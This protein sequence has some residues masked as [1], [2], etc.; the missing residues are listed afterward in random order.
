MYAIEQV[1]ALKILPSR[2]K[3][4]L[5][6]IIRDL[7]LL[8]KIRAS[9]RTE[10]FIA[11]PNARLRGCVITSA[12]TKEPVAILVVLRPDDTVETIV[13]VLVHE[14]MHY[15]I[16]KEVGYRASRAYD[17]VAY[18]VERLAELRE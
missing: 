13:K 7:L 4:L 11:A 10:L 1:L 16:N 17:R 15:T 2:I 5:S 8:V 3:L 9:D 14:W 12:I 18:I 6:N